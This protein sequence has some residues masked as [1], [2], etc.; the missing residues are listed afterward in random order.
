M[1]VFKDI[2]TANGFAGEFFA[3]DHGAASVPGE[4]HTHRV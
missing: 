3:F 2:E 4:Y 1:A